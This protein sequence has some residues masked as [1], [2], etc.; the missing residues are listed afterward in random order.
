MFTI[1]SYLFCSYCSL[2]SKHNF[3]HSVHLPIE[4]NHTTLTPMLILLVIF[5]V[6]Y[7]LLF[8]LSLRFL[9]LAS[10]RTLVFHSKLLFCKVVSS[11]ESDSFGQIQRIRHYFFHA[12][13]RHL[14][15]FAQNA[16]LD[17]VRARIPLVFHQ[18]VPPHFIPNA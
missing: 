18:A 17:T 13:L 4:S 2:C 5:F 11:Y 6:P 12:T 15:Y 9:F 10:L 1:S 14:K 8:I 7:S 16:L 3:L